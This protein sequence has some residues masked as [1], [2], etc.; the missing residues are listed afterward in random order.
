MLSYQLNAQYNKAAAVAPTQAPV[1][2]PFQS[3]GWNPEQYCAICSLAASHIGP[4]KATSTDTALIQ[5][6]ENINT[7]SLF[8]KILLNSK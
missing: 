2:P 7:N 3:P 4:A 5:Q 8:K 1:P 6:Q